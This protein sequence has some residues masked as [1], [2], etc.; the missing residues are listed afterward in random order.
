MNGHYN[1]MFI[2]LIF[3]HNDKVEGLFS[4]LTLLLEIRHIE[5]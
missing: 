1:L 4:D 5:F 2:A 3:V